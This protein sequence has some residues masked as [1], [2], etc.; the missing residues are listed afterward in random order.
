M[1]R[2]LKLF[3]AKKNKF[4]HSNYW[5]KLLVSTES[6]M[7]AFSNTSYATPK[8]MSQTPGIKYSGY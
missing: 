5:L 4:M 8:I 3:K 6:F 7:S 1:I 2:I